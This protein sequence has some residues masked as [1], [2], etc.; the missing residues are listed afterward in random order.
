MIT[1]PIYIRIY[2]KTWKELRRNFKAQRGESAASY[3][4]RL[5]EELKN[6]N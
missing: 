1:K 6:G 3:F 4:Q 5:A 2:Y